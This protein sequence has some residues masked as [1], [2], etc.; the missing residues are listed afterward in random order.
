MSEPAPHLLVVDDDQRL[1]DLLSRYLT[2]EGFM[3][4]TAGDA[5]EATQKL[6]ALSFDLLILDIMLPGA[7][8]LDLARA[9]RRDSNVAI[10]LLSAKGEPD[11]R[12]V[13]LQAGADD[14]LAKPFE[15]RE[16]L[17]RIN[18]ILR[19]ALPEKRKSDEPARFGPFSFD[20]ERG[21]LNESGTP[22]HLTETESALLTLLV[23]NSGAPVSREAL[24]GGGE[25]DFV[26]PGKLRS[27]DVQ[28]TRLRRKLEADPRFPRYLQT[29]RGKGYILITD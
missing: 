28:I 11:D 4:T 19:R 12:I 3:V 23:Q 2:T 9:L 27:V 25:A 6:D 15:P 1:C 17:L 16:L 5:E 22:I 29:V 7:S 20:P 26:E 10:L 24:A 18:A 21:Q 13:G 14:Y 8:G